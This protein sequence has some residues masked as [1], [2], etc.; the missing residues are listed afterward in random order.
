MNTK[1]IATI[2]FF[3]LK[4]FTVFGQQKKGIVAMPVELDELMVSKL[5]TE[6]ELTN[7]FNAEVFKTA[8]R[9]NDTIFNWINGIVLTG[10]YHTRTK[11]SSTFKK[12]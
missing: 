3:T 11:K 12:E 5:S 8:G 2:A 1:I 10:E 6:K 9:K 7:R 4:S